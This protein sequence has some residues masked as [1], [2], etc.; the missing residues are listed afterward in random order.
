MAYDTDSAWICGGEILPGGY[1]PDTIP[2]VPMTVMVQFDMGT[3]SFTNNSIANSNV[4][5]ILERGAMHY[6]HSFGTKGLYVVMGGAQN[7][8]SEGPPLISFDTV[9][10][11]DPAKREW[12]NQTTTG[13]PPAPRMEFCTVGINSTNGTYEMQVG[14]L[15]VL[16]QG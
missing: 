11:L 15:A 7:F 16:D 1:N 4:T 3:R 5:G 13:S 6:V 14:H 12:W 2:P 9:A 10:I 8:S